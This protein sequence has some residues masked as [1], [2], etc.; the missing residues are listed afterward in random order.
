MRRS[1]VPLSGSPSRNYDRWEVMEVDVTSC[2]PQSVPMAPEKGNAMSEGEARIEA[3]AP[4]EAQRAT[5]K[6]ERY[7]RVGLAGALAPC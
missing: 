4:G 3:V 1:R 7:D 6:E 5:S 2:E